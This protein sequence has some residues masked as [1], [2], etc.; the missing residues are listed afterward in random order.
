MINNKGYVFTPVIMLI[1]IF[2]AL[3]VFSLKKTMDDS[4]NQAGLIMGL[5]DKI[6]YNYTKQVINLIDDFKLLAYENLSNS[7][8]VD[9][10]NNSKGGIITT[11]NPSFEL[12]IPART[13][14][15]NIVNIT[16]KSRIENVTIEYPISSLIKA[17]EEFNEEEIQTCLNNNEC[18]SKR[19]QYDILLKNCLDNISKNSFLLR[20]STIPLLIGN[21]IIVNLEFY[22]KGM[23]LLFPFKL[24]TFNFNC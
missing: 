23:T 12:L 7:S 21:S 5:M 19:E 24:G 13:F 1:I 17:K 9:S 10:F 11:D 6:N 4:V 3:T 18:S 22:N 16:Y 15:E 2:I 8:L 20:N 14:N